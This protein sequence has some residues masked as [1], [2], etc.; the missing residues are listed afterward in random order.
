MPIW[1][2]GQID[3]LA[4]PNGT[5]LSNEL[6]RKHISIVRENVPYREALEKAAKMAK[7]IPPVLTLAKARN[8]K[9]EDLDALINQNLKAQKSLERKRENE[10]GTTVSSIIV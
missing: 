1:K 3:A 10:K 9:R 6:T 8:K 5:F 4:L 7:Y 2:N